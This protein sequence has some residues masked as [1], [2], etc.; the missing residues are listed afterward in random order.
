[1]LGGLVGL[2]NSTIVMDVIRCLAFDGLME[3]V[4]VVVKQ[5]FRQYPVESSL[6]GEKEQ[7]KEFLLQGLKEP[8]DLSI[9]LRMSD[10]GPYMSGVLRIQK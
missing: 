8:L 5:I 3:T 9:G 10:G 4:S 2:G 6:A 7:A 1:M